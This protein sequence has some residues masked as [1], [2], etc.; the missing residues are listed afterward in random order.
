MV[1][2]SHWDPKLGLEW[3]DLFTP[4]AYSSESRAKAFLWL[5]YHYVESMS[6]TENPFADDYTK[7]HKGYCPK[8]IPLTPEEMALENVD[9][10]EELAAG[11]AMTERRKDF[12]A[13]F[14]QASSA[15]ITQKEKEKERE[16]ERG[17]GSVSH[18][19]PGRR[20]SAPLQSRSHS[21][22]ER[23]ATIPAPT[24][25]SRISIIESGMPSRGESFLSP[26]ISLD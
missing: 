18:G 25:Q 7:T 11:V 16:K 19:S 10:Q 2:C 15:K 12:L 1:G 5:C 26:S 14:K 13:K 21:T 6:I 9:T 3:G 8:L 17:V 22:R 23:L 20:E 24:P 4:I